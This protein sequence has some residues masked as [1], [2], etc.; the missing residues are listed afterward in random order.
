MKGFLNNS[1]KVS[2]KKLTKSHPYSKSFIQG[3]VTVPVAYFWH[4]FYLKTN[5]FKSLNILNSILTVKKMFKSLEKRC[6]TLVTVTVTKIVHVILLELPL[7]YFHFLL[8]NIISKSFQL[9]SC[10]L[11]SSLEPASK[12]I[13]TPCTTACQVGFILFFC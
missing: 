5:R 11:G 13:K 6:R 9:S 8:D 7:N 3:P 10:N 12:L 4:R 2:S 1:I